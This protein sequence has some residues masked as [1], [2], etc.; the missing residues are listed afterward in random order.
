[1]R[2]GV[3]MLWVNTMRLRSFG[4]RKAMVSQKIKS[5]E[6]LT[7]NLTRTAPDYAMRYYA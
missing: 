2:E 6:T 3:A 5:L 7:Q 1:M 4:R